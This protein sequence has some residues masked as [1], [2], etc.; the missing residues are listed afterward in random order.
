MN[1]LKDEFG[2]LK[3]GGRTLKEY[4]DDFCSL[5]RY[6]PEDIDTDA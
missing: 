1:L 2:T 5:S 3:R 6:P 4:I